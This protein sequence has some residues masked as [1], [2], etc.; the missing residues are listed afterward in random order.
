MKKTCIIGAALLM[1]AA[2]AN[3]QD[4]AT[5]EKKAS[6]IHFGLEAGINLNNLYRSDRDNYVTSN[7]LKV[8]YHGGF[9]V[10]FGTG[11][12]AVQP[13]LRYSQK[14]GE[15]TRSFSDPFVAIETKDKLTLHYIEMPLNFIWHAGYWGEGRF[16]I[17]VGPYVSYLVN[18]QDKHKLKTTNRET[19]VETVFEGQ[20]KLTVGNKDESDIARWDYG[21][22]AFLGY[23]FTSGMYVKAGGSLGFAD[24]QRGQFVGQYNNRNY[25]FYFTLGYMF[26][27]KCK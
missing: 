26:G 9:I 8:G 15:I 5:D 12:F 27:Y 10:N 1:L 14:G 18:A 23:E 19:G 6:P 11:S 25:N 20:T 13:G 22:N 17:G 2:G 16:M 24:L 3:A 21:G 7:M 4:M